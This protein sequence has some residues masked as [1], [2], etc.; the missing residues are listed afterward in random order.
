MHCYPNGPQ[1]LAKHCFC[2]DITRKGARTTGACRIGSPLTSREHNAIRARLLKFSRVFAAG[3]QE[4]QLILRRVVT[5][6]SDR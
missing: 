4:L 5:V 3:R 1:N 2:S 6:E